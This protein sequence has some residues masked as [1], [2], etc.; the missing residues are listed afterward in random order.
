[1]TVLVRYSPTSLSREAY[2]R[3]EDALRSQ[4]LEGPPREL[5]LHVLFGD[6]PRL[7]V[8]EIWESEEAWRQF[9]DGAL[10]QAF[11]DAGLEMPQPD[12]LAVHEMWGSA[13]QQPA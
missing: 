4:G 13:V 9:R 2:D 12:I 10:A 6:D 11:D 3:V 5:S 7:R 1:M 8:S